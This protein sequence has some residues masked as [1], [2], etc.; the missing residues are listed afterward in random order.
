[1]SEEHFRVYTCTC[2]RVFDSK[3]RSRQSAA[4]FSQSSSHSGDEKLSL[5]HANLVVILSRSMTRPVLSFLYPVSNHTWIATMSIS[6]A[7]D[8]K[9][10]IN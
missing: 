8:G 7:S 10:F 6:R 3:S 4:K 1:M 2:F 9:G 5:G